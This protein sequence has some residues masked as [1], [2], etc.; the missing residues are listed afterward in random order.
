MTD[1]G[2]TTAG[3]VIKPL[4]QILSELEADVL[5]NIDPSLDTSPEEPLGQMLGIFASYLAANW[6]LLQ[7]A[8][9]AYNR[10]E[11]EFFLLDSI[12]TLTGC[13]RLAAQY[14][15]VRIPLALNAGT[16]IIT[17]VAKI[18]VASRPT[19]I[20]VAAET[21]TAGTTNT[22]NVLFRADT[23]GARVLNA[24]TTLAITAPI[25]GWTGVSPNPLAADV[26]RLEEVDEDYR[27]RQV[28]ELALEGSSTTVAVRAALLKLLQQAN[29]TFDCRVFENVTTT[30][31]GNGL[32]PHTM[33]AVIWDGLSTPLSNDAIAQVLWDNKGGGIGY[34]GSLTGTATDSA[35]NPQ[36]MNFDRVTQL[37]VYV[38]VTVKKN[39][40]FPADGTTQVTNAIV[41]AVANLGVGNNVIVIPLEA[42]P[43]AVPGVLDVTAFTLGFSASPTGTTNL[44]VSPTAIA[45]LDPSHVTVTVTT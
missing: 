31:D 16:S 26:G 24:T 2:V 20:W 17:G 35:L 32:P 34:V 37:Q 6:E 4:Q 1:Y 7:T 30:T 28:Q 14:S 5:A 41:A 18:N 9:N 12:G 45:L 19:D 39:S 27:T 40:K 22:Y 43:F 25:S 21:V 38:N 23:L 13:P 10:T 36:V 44:T 42:A 33:K 29:S 11:A 3:F 15:T 8:F